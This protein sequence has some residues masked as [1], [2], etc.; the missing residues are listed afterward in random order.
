VEFVA[1]EKSALNQI[2]GDSTL[3]VFQKGKDQ[4]AAIETFMQKYRKGFSLD[5]FGVT[6]R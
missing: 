2:Y 6:V 4:K 3:T 1:S 5:H